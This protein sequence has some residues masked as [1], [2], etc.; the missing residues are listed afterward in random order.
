MLDEIEIKISLES[1]I[2][3]QGLPKRIITNEPLFVISGE[4]KCIILQQR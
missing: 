4:A 1:G 2:A 3:S